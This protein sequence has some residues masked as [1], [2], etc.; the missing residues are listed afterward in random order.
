MKSPRRSVLHLN[1]NDTVTL[2]ANKLRAIVPFDTCVYLS[3]DEHSGKAMAAHVVGEDVEVFTRRRINI[4]DGIT[5]WVIANA[6]SMCNAS[7][8]LDLVGVRKK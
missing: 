4:G 6:R 7:P 8:D 2:V 1:L 5:G 3:V